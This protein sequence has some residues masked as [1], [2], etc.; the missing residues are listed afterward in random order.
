MARNIGF[1]MSAF[2]LT[3]NISKIFPFFWQVDV[4]R[5]CSCSVKQLSYQKGGQHC[6]DIIQLS[7]ALHFCLH[8]SPAF[9]LVPVLIADL[10]ETS[11]LHQANVY[12]T[13]EALNKKIPVPGNLNVL[14]NTSVSSQNLQAAP[15]IDDFDI[16]AL[17]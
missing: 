1:C 17:S 10:L 9:E 11:A 2:D 5:P 15:A 13:E 7:G 12:Q 16:C 8:S 3:M 14:I 4:P 6:N